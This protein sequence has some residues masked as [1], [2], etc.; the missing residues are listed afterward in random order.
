ML[1]IEAGKTIVVDLQETV[2]LADR[3]G[4]TIIA[5]DQPLAA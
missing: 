1:A 4:L 2:A 3:Y 5:L